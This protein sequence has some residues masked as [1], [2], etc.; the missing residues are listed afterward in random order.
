[1]ADIRRGVDPTAGTGRVEPEVQVLS[2][3]RLDNTVEAAGGVLPGPLLRTR[4]RP[5]LLSTMGV[6]LLVRGLRMTSPFGPT[7]MPWNPSHHNGSKRGHFRLAHSATTTT[8]TSTPGSGC[9]PLPQSTTAPPT[10]SERCASPPSTAPTRPIPTGSATAD[11]DPRN[12]PPRP[13]STSPHEK[14]SY[15]AHRPLLSHQP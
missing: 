6:V 12:Y 14:R 9:T 13:G 11:R 7:V 8:S 5:L 4:S 15:K 2:I 3:A 1:M 10:R